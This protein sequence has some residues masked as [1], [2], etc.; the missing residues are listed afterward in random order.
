MKVLL[1]GAT[2]FTGS[3]V[4]QELL[5][6]GI[7]VRCF[8]RRTSQLD[9]LPTANVELA[10]G[11]LDQPETLIEALDGM[12]ALVN[13]ASIGF[14]HA[15]GIVSATRQAGIKRCL[16][17]STTAIFTTLN[18][19][20]KAVRIAAE[21]TIQDSGLA[22][23]I[24]RP[25][26]I[27][28]SSRDRNMYRLVRY[29]R[30]WPVMPMPGS[31]ENLQQPVYVNDVARAVVVVLSTDRTIGK[32][33]N[34][35]GSKPLTFKEVVETISNLLGRNILKV[36]LP[37]S[38]F[39]KLLRLCEGYGLTLPIRAEQIL[40]LNEGKTFDFDD[41]SRDFG[42]APRAFEEGIAL[43]LKEMGYN[44]QI[45]P[46]PSPGATGQA[47]ITRIKSSHAPVK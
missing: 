6:S 3:T 38:P 13:T 43:E 18:A 19:P 45:T 23:T 22:Y 40:R 46:V 10:F 31:G 47:Q 16:F 11:D 7:N 9:C 1:T 12:D 35:P 4:V 36:N 33:Y 29:L 32:A 24:L 27:Y 30:R 34:I 42:Y 41:A 15:P 14:G 21:H 44:P 2:G 25:T 5:D 37:I 8:V 26:M 39:V 17:I 20:S 28:G